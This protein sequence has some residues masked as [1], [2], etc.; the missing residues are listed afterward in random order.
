M[1]FLSTLVGKVIAIVL[2]LYVCVTLLPA[3]LNARNDLAVTMGMVLIVIL[4]VLGIKFH[5]KIMDW[6][7]S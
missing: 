6:L 3:L 7:K 5:E 4:I 1:L 2:G